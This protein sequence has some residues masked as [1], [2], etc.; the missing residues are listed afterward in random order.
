M[1]VGTGGCYVG[2]AA[3]FK[4]IAPNAGCVAVEP[5]SSQPLAGKQPTGGHRN[6]GTGVGYVTPLM[7]LDLVDPTFA[8]SDAQA[9]DMAR[10]LAREEGLFGGYSTGA[11]ITA[12][13]RVAQKLG[14]GKRVVTVLCDS[15]LRYLGGDLFRF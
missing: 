7:N 2:N 13:I 4:S 6:E 5:E 14:P 1:A 11:N 8:V 10:K 15:G 3:Y 12:A 9:A